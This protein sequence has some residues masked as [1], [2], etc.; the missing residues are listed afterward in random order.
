MN[1]ESN[2]RESP[3]I[4]DVGS[5]RLF[6]IGDIHGCLDELVILVDYLKTEEGL[7]PD[8]QVIF[9]G[10]YIDRGPDSKGVIDYLIS[11]KKEFPETIFLKGNHEDMLLGFLGIGGC[12]G[13]VYI[14]NGGDTC[15]QSYGIDSSKMPEEVTEEMPKSHVDFFASLERYVVL[16][17]YVFVHAGLNPL[18]DILSQ[19]DEEIVWI[20]NDFIHNVHTFEKTVVFGHTPY[21]E[22]FFD[23]PYKIGI[24]T[25]LVYGN[26][27]TCVEFRSNTVYQV[28]AGAGELIL[29]DFDWPL[30]E[31]RKEERAG[32]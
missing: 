8:D 27:L 15:L 1:S 30:D 29:A 19:V 17:S 24:D 6:G 4:L 32:E 9:I 5:K 14:L 18:R 22:V 13:E 25:G 12:M 31:F 16:P 21:H 20:R 10:D 3:R 7:S 11:F 23:F 28:I 2:G 26:K